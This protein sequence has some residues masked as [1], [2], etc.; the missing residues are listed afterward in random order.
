M[1]SRGFTPRAWATVRNVLRD[2][3]FRAYF[4][5][6]TASLSGSGIEDVALGWQIFQLRHSAFDLGFV[7]LLLFL[8]QLLLAIPAGL[9]ADR[10]ERKR[11]CVLTTAGECAAL[12]VFAAL[13]FARSP[14][15]A[16]YFAAVA[17]IG[18]AHALRV[19]AQRSILATIV[20]SE[21]FV[22]AQSL[23]SSA[24]E[25]VSVAAPATAGFLV[26]LSTPLAFGCAAGFYA[27]SSL[28]FAQL[29][30]REAGPK[31]AIGARTALEGIGFIFSQKVV[32]G[33]I[34]LDL[35]AVL[36]GGATALLPVYATAILHVG[37]SGLGLLRAAPAVGA[38][39]V[40]LAIARKPIV[41]HGGRLLFFCVAGFG[42]ATIVF[43]LSRNLPLSLLALACTGGFDMVSV[44]IRSSLVQLGTPNAM[45][46]RVT[47]V[48]NVFIGA[49]NELGA[50]E[51]GTL[52]GIAGAP[53]SVV[54][55][56]IATLAVIALFAVRF[57]ALRRFDRLDRSERE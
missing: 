9:L 26:A 52:A 39:V 53:A 11:V 1:R 17:L 31:V 35:F 6:R 30:P 18:V 27:I 7:G 49:S 54:I 19:P 57:P 46:G 2:A 43:G 16:P 41:R 20:R 55:G 25:L 33:A 29:R 56:G 3:D 45:R 51:S 12:G 37:A 44:V 13:A 42:V 40:A 14:N 50:F 36:F 8:P 23:S 47:A 32:L 48:E 15:V 5:A 22:R 24:Q 21:Q 4:F 38:L 10:F 34:S 28:A